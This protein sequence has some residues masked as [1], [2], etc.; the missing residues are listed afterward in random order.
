M[1]R[2]K[3]LGDETTKETRIMETGSQTGK[4]TMDEIGCETKATQMSNSG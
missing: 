2:V 1:P 3:N 4:Q